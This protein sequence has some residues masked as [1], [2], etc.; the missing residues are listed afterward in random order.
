MGKT[1]Q[2]P[3]VGEGITEGEVVKWLVSEGDE[4][5][6]D[7]PLAE[8][9]TDKAIVEMP[10]PFAGVVLKLHVNDKDII[11]VGDP[12]VTIGTRDEAAKKIPAAERAAALQAAVP[13]V[14]EVPPSPALPAVAPAPGDT[15]EQPV[16]AAALATPKV[17]NLARE[18]GLKLTSIRGTGP[19]GRVTE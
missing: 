18:L 17:R 1:F 7:Q 14:P 4:V 19:G 15:G 3:D 10:S 12:L 16:E 8:I 11:K 6:V 5:K 9:E 2:F 13:V